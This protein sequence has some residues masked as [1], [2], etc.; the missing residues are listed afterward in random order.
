MLR[1]EFRDFWQ[2]FD[3]R[4]SLW[5]RIFSEMGNIEIVDGDGDV[6]IYSCFGTSNRTFGGCKVFVTG[7][8]RRPDFRDADF[9][10]G[11][12]HIVDERYLRYPLWAWY[13]AAN[14]LRHPYGENITEK[15]TDFCAFVVSNPRNPI[16]NAI[17]QELSRHRHVHSGGRL[18][19]NDSM[20]GESR[21][22]H[23]S[24]QAISYL[25]RFQFTIAAENSAFPGYTTEKLL[26]AFV[27]GSIP[28]YWGDPLVDC[29]F[30][31]RS[32]INFADYGTV[33]GVVRAVLELADDPA[34]MDRMR[35]IAPVPED[36]WNRSASHDLLT[37]F[38]ERVFAYAAEP[39]H[40][41]PWERRRLGGIAAEVTRPA[42]RRGR[43]IFDR[44]LR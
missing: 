2:G 18:F 34:A 13:D 36:S 6:C 29:D 12:D 9:C 32:F 41:R 39:Q 27:A 28:I 40:V 10:I 22:G 26:Q 5:S 4:D 30:D 44:L 38:F 16:R 25:Q 42:V 11:F 37:D 31:P 35:S 24:S 3:S 15:Q 14:E 19:N 33:S 7:E 20:E 17:F 43:S 1:V 23:H 21:R 8:N